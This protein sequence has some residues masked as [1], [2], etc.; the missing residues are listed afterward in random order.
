MSFEENWLRPTCRVV[1]DDGSWLV[2]DPLLTLTDRG[3]AKWLE[4]GLRMLQEYLPLETEG[5]E[6]LVLSS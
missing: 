3:G 1:Y 6:R 5:V 4:T 2:V